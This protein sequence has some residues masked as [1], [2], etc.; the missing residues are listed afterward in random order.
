MY[1]HV[2]NIWYTNADSLHNKLIE[3]NL[4]LNNSLTKPDVIAI[5]EAKSKRNGAINKAEFALPQYRLFTNNFEKDN[6][7]L[8]YTS[9]AADE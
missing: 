9:D 2:L 3:L 6:S 7:C 8:L 4:L 5:T 1:N